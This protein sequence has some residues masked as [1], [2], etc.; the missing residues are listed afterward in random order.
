MH[1][2][3]NLDEINATPVSYKQ[4]QAHKNGHVEDWNGDG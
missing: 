4:A 3:S 1:N 2:L